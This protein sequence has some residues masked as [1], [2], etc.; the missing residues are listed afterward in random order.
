MYLRIEIILEKRLVG[1]R[2]KTSFSNDRTRELW[3]NFMPRRNDILNSLSTNLI[4]LQIYHESFGIS[5]FNP[6]MEFEKW[7]LS[8]VS[9]IM[10]VPENMESF[11]LM[12]GLYAVFFTQKCDLYSGRDI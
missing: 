1:N 4:S 6:T 2:V 5:E 7:A 12:S 11:T 10:E 3:Q 8:E 9:D